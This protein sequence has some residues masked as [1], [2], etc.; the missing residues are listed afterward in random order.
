MISQSRSL[1]HHFANSLN[2]DHLSKH[3]ILHALSPKLVKP[4]AVFSLFDTDPL[5][6]LNDAKDISAAKMNRYG[7]KITQNP[8]DI[9]KQKLG[10]CLI[11]IFT[12]YIK[13]PR[14]HLKTSQILAYHMTDLVD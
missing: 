9:S 3:I 13:N 6:T 1:I 7:F 8:R 11:K 5:L 10:V 2:I 12:D 14:P 4:P